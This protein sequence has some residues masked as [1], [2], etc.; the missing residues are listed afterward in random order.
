LSA[1]LAFFLADFQSTPMWLW[2]AFIGIAVTL[3]LLVGGVVFSLWTTRT[4]GNAG[5]VPQAARVAAEN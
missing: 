5:G 4:G 3:F 1:I 2:A